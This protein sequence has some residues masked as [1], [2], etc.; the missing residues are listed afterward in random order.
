VWEAVFKAARDGN[1]TMLSLLAD[2][3]ADLSSTNYDKVRSVDLENAAPA[4]LLMGYGISLRQALSL[5][6]V[7]FVVHQVHSTCLEHLDSFYNVHCLTYSGT[8]D[9]CTAYRCQE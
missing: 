8:A 6:M 3:G 9:E 2:S 5:F 7:P 1:I 4:V